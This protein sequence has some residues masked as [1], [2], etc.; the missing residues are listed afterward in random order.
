MSLRVCHVVCHFVFFTLQDTEEPEEQSFSNK[1]AQTHL[2][3]DTGICRIFPFDFDVILCYRLCSTMFAI[4]LEAIAITDYV[5]LP[6]RKS[7]LATPSHA[8]A[9]Q[10]RCVAYTM[11][12]WPCH[13]H[14]L[15]C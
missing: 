5:Q 3:L 7:R 15:T 13:G 11:T 8:M 1:I 9:R 4:R 2:A 12:S 6:V 10:G 14:V